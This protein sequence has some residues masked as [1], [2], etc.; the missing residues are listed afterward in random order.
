MAALLMA[1][2]SWDRCNPP[3]E[4]PPGCR[5]PERWA[6]WFP[7]YRKH[8]PSEFGW[9]RYVL[10]TEKSPCFGLRIALRGLLDADAPT[11]PHEATPGPASVV[12]S[13]IC[14]WCGTGI[15]KHSWVGW[16]HV[17]RGFLLCME[18]AEDGLALSVAEPG[19]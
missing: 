17:E 18:P 8:Q 6:Y 14:R 4:P 19:R 2:P 5:A 1:R 7:E 9:C 13:A 12:A 10:C 11:R 3:A 16:M 15:V